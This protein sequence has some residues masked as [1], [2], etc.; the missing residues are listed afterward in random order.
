VLH[1]TA[2]GATQSYWTILHSSLKLNKPD[3]LPLG[4]L[5]SCNILCALR[6]L[7][8]LTAES[9]GIEERFMKLEAVIMGLINNA[10]VAKMEYWECVIEGIANLILS[11]RSFIAL[12][13]IMFSFACSVIPFRKK[14]IQLFQSPFKEIDFKRS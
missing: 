14:E 6:A 13:L 1:E 5:M 4:I 9:F 11:Y 2:F 7:R 12:T 3:L 8:I 10:S